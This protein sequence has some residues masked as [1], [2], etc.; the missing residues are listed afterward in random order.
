M[1]NFKIQESGVIVNIQGFICHMPSCSWTMGSE[2]FIIFF[3]FVIKTVSDT[4][5]PRLDFQGIVNRLFPPFLVCNLL[6]VFG[7]MR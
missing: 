6:F 4:L 1:C 7:E 5:K 3:F 2:I